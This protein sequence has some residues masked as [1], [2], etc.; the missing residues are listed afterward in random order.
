MKRVGFSLALVVAVTL[1]WAVGSAHAHDQGTADYVYHGHAVGG[2]DQYHCAGGGSS[3][4]EDGSDMKYRATTF[5]RKSGFCVNG[6]NVGVN[7]LKAQ[8]NL[9][10][11]IEG[12]PTICD[13]T[14]VFENG[15]SRIYTAFFLADCGDGTYSNTSLHDVKLDGDWYDA[16]LYSGYHT[17]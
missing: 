9:I 2:A 15:G 10:Y 4:L 13:S 7:E 1:G 12:T 11:W 14:N 3:L 8:G 16:I 17:L 6:Y 5:S